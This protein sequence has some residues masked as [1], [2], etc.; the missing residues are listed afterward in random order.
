MTL[1]TVIAA[2]WGVWHC[3]DKR[4]KDPATGDLYDDRSEKHVTLSCPDGR[5]IV[6]Y[7]GLGALHDG[8]H[9]SEWI[10]DQLVGE[11]RTLDESFIRLREA[12]NHELAPSLRKWRLAHVFM[13]S[14]IAADGVWV[15][16]IANVDKWD[17]PIRA[18]FA[19]RSVRLADEG[20]VGIGGDRGAVTPDD[21]ETMKKLRNVHPKHLEDYCGMLAHV[22]QRAA[23]RSDWI[24]ESC[25]T[26]FYTPESEGLQ[27]REFFADEANEEAAVMS[28]SHMLFGIDVGPMMEHLH[29]E[30]RRMGDPTYDP[31]SD[32]A[33]AE[34]DAAARRGTGEDRRRS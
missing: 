32:E 7:T 26:A 15:G 14:A 21:L 8:R 11:T 9:I 16:E 23:E 2:P 13:L 33:R 19:T 10:R 28:M 20:F 3:A 25:W 17:G 12:A 27:A 29:R 31:N 34:G 30:A 22:N 6:T 24:S 5:G 4:L 18:E 1:I